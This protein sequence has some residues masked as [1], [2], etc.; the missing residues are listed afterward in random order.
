MANCNREVSAALATL[1]GLVR[2][3][4]A[5]LYGAAPAP[6]LAGDILDNINDIILYLDPNYVQTNPSPPDCQPAYQAA[7]QMKKHTY[8]LIGNLNSLK[9]YIA[10]VQRTNKPLTG[11]SLNIYKKSVKNVASGFNLQNTF[12]FT[13]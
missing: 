11:S 12:R 4:I 7:L 6:V 10:I 8:V 3:E 9:N 13:Y 5:F 2:S 1:T